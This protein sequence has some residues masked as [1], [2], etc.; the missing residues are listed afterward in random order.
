MIFSS[1]RTR[2]TLSDS[3][4]VKCF[5]IK[6]TCVLNIVEQAKL[7]ALAIIMVV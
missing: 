5:D 3:L 7:A 2:L 6:R 4:L 1:I